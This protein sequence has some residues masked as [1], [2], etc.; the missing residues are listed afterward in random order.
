[1]SASC[2]ES[3]QVHPT[4]AGLM[5]DHSYTILDA[6]EAMNIRLLQIRNPWGH[7]E[8]KGDWSDFSPLWTESAKAAFGVDDLNPD[9][10]AFWM[11]WEDFFKI[12]YNCYSLF[13]SS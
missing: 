3:S 8:W 5:V 12:F 4:E 9:D 13:L 1:M 2:E 11:C 10:G 7:G 6:K